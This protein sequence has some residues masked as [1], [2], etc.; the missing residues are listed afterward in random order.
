MLTWMIGILVVSGIQTGFGYY[1]L[2]QVINASYQCIAYG[3]NVWKEKKK[4]SLM[5]AA[6]LVILV[7]LEVYSGGSDL[8]VSG[9]WHVPLLGE[10]CWPI[11]FW[12]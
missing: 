12:K 7:D 5:N 10:K 11:S 9:S 1:Q 4:T 2:T 8:Q 6:S 3:G